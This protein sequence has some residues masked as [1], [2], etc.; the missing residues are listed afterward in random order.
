MGHLGTG[1]QQ[2]VNDSVEQANEHQQDA[3]HHGD[4]GGRLTVFG[5]VKQ[6][7][8]VAGDQLPPGRDQED[9]R[10]DGSDGLGEGV[11]NAGKEGVFQHGQRDAAEGIAGVGTQDGRGFLDRVV[12]LQQS[13]GAGLDGYRHVPK[14]EHDHQNQSSASE[15]Q[16]LGVE[17]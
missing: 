14:G 3:H 9:H 2:E 17:T 12:D 10:A 16:R 13:G 7:V 15:G 1:R 6:G 11:D 5:Q 4:E 8:D